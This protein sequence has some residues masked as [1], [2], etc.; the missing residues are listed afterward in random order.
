MADPWNAELYQEVYRFIL[1]NK[2]LN[3]AFTPIESKYVDYEYG[4][5]FQH[6]E[7]LIFN[8]DIYDQDLFKYARMVLADK[9]YD[10]NH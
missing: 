4:G 8:K 7:S 2:L 3:G 9:K 5:F 6:I 1:D 10:R